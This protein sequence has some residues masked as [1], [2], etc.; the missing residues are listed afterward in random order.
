VERKYYTIEESIV[1]DLNFINNFPSVFSSIEEEISK[2]LIIPDCF[3]AALG[4]Y[5]NYSREYTKLKKF[6][7]AL[8]FFLCNNSLPE[9]YFECK[10]IIESS[11]WLN[12]KNMSM[13]LIMQ[14]TR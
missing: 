12:I 2:L 4:S 1:I 3:Q 8:T 14:F 7:D 10:K 11:E 6:L 9:N 13:E 5:S